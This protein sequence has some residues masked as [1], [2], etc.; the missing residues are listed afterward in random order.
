[1]KLHVRTIYLLLAFAL[2]AAGGCGEDT[3][4]YQELFPGKWKEIARGN[5]TD[6]EFFPGGRTLEFLPDGA[7]HVASKTGRYWVDAKFL[8]AKMLESGFDGTNTY[9]YTFTGTDTL[10]LDFVDGVLLKMMSTYTSHIY[11]RLT[12]IEP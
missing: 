8:Y 1:M 11:E 4:K 6:I 5:E 2:L 9:R 12:A 3:S 7:Y 10:R